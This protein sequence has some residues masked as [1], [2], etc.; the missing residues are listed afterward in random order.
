M[1]T[2]LTDTAITKAL[3]DT[4]I[5]KALRVAAETK[6]RK[7][8]SDP[9][10]PGLRLRVTPAGG[11]AWVLACR[12]RAG[13]MRRFPLG[14]YSAADGAMGIKDAREAARAMR[15]KVRQE[16]ADPIAEQRAER[17]RAAATRA[18]IGTLQSLLDQFGRQRASGLKSWPAYERNIDR[19]FKPHLAKAL[20][21]LTLADLQLTADLYPAKQQ[22][23][24]AV[25]CIRPMLKWAS[26]PGR[27]LVPAE[28]V[29]I[30][31]PATVRRRDRVLSH[32]ELARLLPVLI[33]SESPYAAAMMMM[34]YTLGRRSE[35]DGAR[36]GDL[37]W[38]AGT[39]TI[40]GERS[41]N[42]QPHTVPLPAQAVELLRARLPAGADPAGLIFTTRG[43]GPLA[44]WDR[45]T[46]AIQSASGTA[47]WHRHDLRRTGATM[48]GD[49]GETPD[50]IEAA[51]NHASIRSP[52]AATY[53]RSRYR[54][55]VAAALQ[56]LADALDGIEAGAAQ[57]V[58]LRA[59]VGAA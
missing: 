8:I 43:G 26:A 5:A 31:Q 49:L 37:D 6:K 11:A 14:V 58:P 20:A 13:R 34:F 57:V 30:T 17:A 28:F 56:R 12:D 29:Q 33:A 3:T 39:L 47:G 4:A 45:E 50:V 23:A 18:G 15:H 42:K 32:A 7:D 44:S 25:R 52:L 27:A 53:N 54:P 51:L 2:Q 10:E 9:R 55:R 21:D 41:K 48:L 19:V 24:L 59:M 35:I 16:G 22:A 40:S 46:K 36:W 38:T 1:P